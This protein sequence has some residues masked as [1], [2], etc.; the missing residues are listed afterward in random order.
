M[1]QVW[2]EPHIPWGPAPRSSSVI[3]KYRPMPENQHSPKTGSV[4]FLFISFSSLFCPEGNRT[5]D[6]PTGAEGVSTEARRA[7]SAGQAQLQRK[8]L[9]QGPG[10]CEVTPL[11]QNWPQALLSNLAQFLGV[12]RGDFS[13]KLP[14]LCQFLFEGPLGYKT[15]IA[16]P[17]SQSTKSCCSCILSTK[18]MKLESMLGVEI[19]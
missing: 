19:A 14:R 11:S 18:T 8:A 10:S 17:R 12:N 4:L 9:G 3:S 13:L 6:D 5:A 2:E 7:R 16:C 1:T 15:A